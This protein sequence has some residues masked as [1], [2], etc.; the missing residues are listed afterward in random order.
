MPKTQLELIT[1]LILSLEE[2]LKND[3]KEINSGN[4]SD[5]R[6]QYLVSEVIGLTNALIS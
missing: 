1:E 5:P 2:S 4:P 3:M 6:V